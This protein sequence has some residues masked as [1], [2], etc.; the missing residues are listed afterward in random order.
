MNTEGNLAFA[1]LEHEEAG[2]F[3][4]GRCRMISRNLCTD[5]TGDYVPQRIPRRDRYA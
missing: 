5:R 2:R 3:G 1:S 4:L